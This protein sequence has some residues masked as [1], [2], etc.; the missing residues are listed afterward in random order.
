M[1]HSKQNHAKLFSLLTQ[2][3]LMSKRH[4]L[5]IE[6]TRGASWSTNDLTDAEVEVLCK[7]LQDQINKTKEAS[8]DEA[9]KARKRV[10]SCA[11]QMGW[12]IRMQSTGELLLKAGKPQLDY[13]M[14]DNWCVK[15]SKVHKP[16]Q[17]HTL[18]ELT[19]KG[20]LVFQFEKMKRNYIKTIR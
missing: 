4:D 3:G 19:G 18:D 9:D 17:D 16:L 20:G 7:Y 1:K 10:L 11:H 14:I 6:L 13:Q 15:H 5:V 12:Y 2:S 8:Q